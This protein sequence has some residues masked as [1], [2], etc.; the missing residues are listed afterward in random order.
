MSMS[1]RNGRMTGRSRSS[2]SL[3]F[4]KTILKIIEV[5]FSY[6]LI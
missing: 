6:F 4:H 2:S 3:L 1:R 5:L